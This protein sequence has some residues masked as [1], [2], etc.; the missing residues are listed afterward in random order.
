[1]ITV[2][3]AVAGASP[4]VGQT[5]VSARQSVEGHVVITRGDGTEFRPPRDRGQTGVMGPIVAADGSAVAWAPRF[6]NCCTS[7]SVALGLVVLVDGATRRFAGN[8]TPIWNFQFEPGGIISFHQETTHGALGVRYE[9]REVRT[10]RVL[11]VFEPIRR[12]PGPGDPPMSGPGPDWVRSLDEMR[13]PM[14]PKLAC[15]S[16]PRSMSEARLAERFGASNVRRGEVFGRDDGTQPGTILFPERSDLRMVATWD[17]DARSALRGILV[18][19]Q[20]TRWRTGH[21]IGIG[22][23]LRSIERRNGGPFRLRGFR[24]ENGGAILSWGGGRLTSDRECATIIFGLPETGDPA[25]VRQLIGPRELSSGHPA[26]QVL[27]PRVV[28]ISISPLQE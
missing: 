10:G 9:R 15:L 2:L 19:E 1:M 7:Y 16:F 25:L 22:E 20:R 27:N 14:D 12:V 4:A 21:G 17:D 23:D 3:F 28:S 5:F 6:D 13:I 8:G 11:D 24:R 18:H 26:L